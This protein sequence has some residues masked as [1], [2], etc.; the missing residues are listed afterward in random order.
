MKPLVAL[1]A[2]VTAVPAADY[3][4]KASPTT[5]VWGYYWAGA[6]PALTIK[7]GDTVTVQTVGTSSPTSLTRAGVK[8]EDVQQQLKDIYE[9]VKKDPKDGGHILTGPIYI[10]GAEPGDVLE[11]RILKIDLAVPY[12]SNG[13]SPNRGVLPATDFQR[14]QTKIIPLDKQRMVGKFADNIE[15]PLHPFFGSMGVAPDAAKG[16]ANSG[17]PAEFAG[18]IDNKDMVVGAKLFIPVFAAGAL[19]EVGD[20]HAGQGNGE[21]DITAMET[22]LDGTFQFI[23][24]KDMHLKGPRGE[25]PT[26]WIAMGLDPDLNQALVNAVRD[27]IDFLV[28]EK[29]MTRE[30]AYALCSVA[31]DFNVTQA[32]DGTKG[33]HGMIPK[34]IFK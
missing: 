8:P 17:P 9:Q 12:A 4:L 14:G 32:V 3:Q 25:T 26:H 13:F 33:V 10:E 20:G 21:A 1:L 15:I 22:S 16:K 29:H 28:T 2:F 5:V 6:K 27:A 19:F 24:R 11:V 34:S 31:V 7:S 23:V 18:N 30:D